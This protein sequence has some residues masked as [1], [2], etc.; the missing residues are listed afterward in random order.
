MMI[1]LF[2]ALLSVSAAT[3]AT[4]QERVVVIG[5]S[6]VEIAYALG[7][8]DQV[9]GVDQHARFP[10]EAANA[11]N[12]GYFR[13]VP[14]EGVLSLKPDLVIA[15]PDAGPPEAFELIAAADIPVLH[16]PD[17]DTPQG[18]PEKIAFMGQALGRVDAATALSATYNSDLARILE[19]PRIAREVLFIMA[20]QGGSPLVAGAGSAPDTMFRAA[21]LGNAAAGLEGYKPLG[22][23]ALIALAPDA[24][25]MMPPHAAKAGGIDR[26]MAMPGLAQTPAAQAER[27]G[28]MEGGLLMR[29]GPR[30]PQALSD[31]RDAFGQ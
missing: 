9:V 23:E 21:G 15:T 3:L 19:A 20:I 22:A 26:V 6:L 25:V 24:V 17:V 29:F 12:I 31:L 1:R 5:P 27:F 10:P 14:V 7:A 28:T 2:L 11:A 8:G 4:A 16:G 30:T 13:K 18:V